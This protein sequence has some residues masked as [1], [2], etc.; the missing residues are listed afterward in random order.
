[1]V[2]TGYGNIGC[3]VSSWGLQNYVDFCLTE[4]W[5]YFQKIL[6]SI[7]PKKKLNGKVS[8]IHMLFKGYG[9]IGCGVLSWGLQNYADFLLKSEQMLNRNLV[10]FSKN[11]ETNST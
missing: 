9:N 6:R 10:L 8:L 3:G 1:M 2:F 11:L 4:I 7:P 5:A